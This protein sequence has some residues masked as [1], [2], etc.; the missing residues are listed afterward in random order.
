RKPSALPAR[1]APSPDA[2]RSRWGKPFALHG[3]RVIDLTWYL[4]SGGAPRFLSAFGADVIKVEWHENLDLRFNYAQMPV[5]GREARRRTSGPLPGDNSTRNLSGQFLNVRSG[6][7]GISLNVR[8]PKGQEILRRLIETADV[9][10]EGFS[11]GVL[12]RWGFGYE[13]LRKL[14]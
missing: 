10:A 4:A 8:H 12:E 7:C 1:T 6:Q 9:V 5:G 14:K 11:P 2:R 13:A 3:V